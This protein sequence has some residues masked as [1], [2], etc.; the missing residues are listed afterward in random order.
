MVRFQ[1][2]R[3]RTFCYVNEVVLVHHRGVVPV[4]LLAYL[5]V[6]WLLNAMDDARESLRCQQSCV[7]R[8]FRWSGFEQCAHFIAEHDLSSYQ[9]KK[10]QMAA[11][12]HCINVGSGSHDYWSHHQSQNQAATVIQRM[13]GIVHKHSHI[14]LPPL[15]LCEP[16]MPITEFDSL[17]PE[18]CVR[19]LVLD[20]FFVTFPLFEMENFL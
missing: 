20:V 5:A 7:A 10:S 3:T 4:K 1:V 12:V 8:C 17:Q 18:T 6:P 15:D 2:V 11:F 19:L 13:H 14:S 9:E 16:S